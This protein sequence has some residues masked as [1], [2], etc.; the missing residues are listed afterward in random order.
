MPHGAGTDRS[1]S[2]ATASF[3]SASRARCSAAERRDSEYVSSVLTLARS[4]EILEDEESVVLAGV[5]CGA[6]GA[7]S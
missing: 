4:T 1:L 6:G 2:R 3:A 5:G 7:P